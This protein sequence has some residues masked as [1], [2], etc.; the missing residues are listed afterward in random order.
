[1]GSQFEDPNLSVRYHYHLSFITIPLLAQIPFGSQLKAM[2][3]Q[4]EDDVYYAASD[5]AGTIHC[6]IS[7]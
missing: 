1:M 4:F 3:S 7:R 5:P 6:E 2:G